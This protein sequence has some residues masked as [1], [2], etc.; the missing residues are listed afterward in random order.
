MIGFVKYMCW[1]PRLATSSTSWSAAILASA[2]SRPCGLRVSSTD[3]ASAR[4]SRWRLT[5]S[6]MKRLMIGARI[7]RTIAMT[8]TTAWAPPPLPPLS[9]LRRPPT[10][11]QN[12]KR[13][14]KS[15]QDR[16][17]ADHDADDEREPDVE[18]AHVRE[19]V[20]EDALE[21]LAVE[22]L[23][24][25]GRD[26]DRRMRR[27]AAGGEGVGRG[28]VD[29]VDLGHRDV[30]GDGQL[31]HDVHQL[32]RGRLVDLWAP[33]TARTSLSPAK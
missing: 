2:R 10:L 16:D 1:V 26:G 4:Y 6:W 31:A 23:E 14:K 29:D 5:A 19:L 30:G 15:A 33:L 24:E 11:P 9:R 28:V 22:L 7:A 17:G 27:V 32:R 20:A 12:V 18:V 8:N 21:L 3:E 25:A 13:R